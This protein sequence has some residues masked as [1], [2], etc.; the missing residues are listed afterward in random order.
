M[1]GT[2]EKEGEGWERRGERGR[3]RESDR[4]RAKDREAGRQADRQIDRHRHKYGYTQIDRQI[5]TEKDKELR[6]V[7]AVLIEAL[8]EIR[9][10]SFVFMLL[11]ICLVSFDHYIYVFAS[12]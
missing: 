8:G 11:P 4:E 6:R 10:C 3:D 9:V 1:K 12:L 5:Q 7:A 2:A